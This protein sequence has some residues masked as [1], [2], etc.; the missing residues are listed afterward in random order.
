MLRLLGIIL[1]QVEAMLVHFGLKV[2]YDTAF[3]AI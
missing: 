1:S 2:C 3:G